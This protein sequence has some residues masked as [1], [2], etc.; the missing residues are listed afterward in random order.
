[1]ADNLTPGQRGYCMSRVR[2]RDTSLERKVRSELFKRGLRFRKNLR[3]LPGQPDIVFMK[4][5]L[6]IFLDGD[7]W[8]GYRFSQWAAKLPHFWL[9][10]ITRNRERDIEK[11]K[12]LKKLGWRVKRYWEHSIDNDLERCVSN[13]VAELLRLRQS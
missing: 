13:M 5:K 8:H 12:E 6:A 3:D 1:M 10:K 9:V 11:R 7:F 4:E 2:G